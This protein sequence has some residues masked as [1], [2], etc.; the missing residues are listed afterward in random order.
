MGR[1]ARRPPPAAVPIEQA[2]ATFAAAVREAGALPSTALSRHGVKKAA[3]PEALALLANLGLEITATR[4][5]VPLAEQLLAHVSPGRA[6]AVRALCRAVAGATAKEVQAG[7]AK[8]AGE[9]RLTLAVRSVELVATRDVAALAPAELRA[10]EK[11]VATLAKALAIA[12]RKSATLLRADV[13]QALGLSLPLAATVTAEKVF[14]AVARLRE[15]SGLTFVPALIRALG[16]SIAREAVHAELLAGA[17]AGVFELRP[18]SGLG[19]LTETELADC[20]AGPQ[21]SRL[22]WVRNLEESP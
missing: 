1:P 22:S 5:R 12:R 16:G 7:L 17:R 13:E 14:A 20:V 9:G 3:R 19:R 2:V 18:E 6:V 8:L 4:V 21:G 11:G 10:L 15:S